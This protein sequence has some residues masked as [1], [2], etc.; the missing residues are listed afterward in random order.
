VSQDRVEIVRATWQALADTGVDAMLE[1]V[2]EDFEMTTT[3]ALA[4]EPDTYRGHAG[5]RRW[6]ET[7]YEAVDEIRLEPVRFEMLGDRVGMAF[8]LTTRGRSTGLEASLE[9]SALCEVAEG[10]VKRLEFFPTWEEAVA[11]GR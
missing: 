10:K 2:H 1:H 11:A 9:A 4:A 7:F 3:P 6:F 8:T 5:V